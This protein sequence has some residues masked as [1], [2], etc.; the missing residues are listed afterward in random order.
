MHLFCTCTVCTK[1]LSVRACVRARVC[2]RVAPCACDRARA[3]AVRVCVHVRM[4]ASMTACLH[5]CACLRAHVCSF[6]FTC[7]S[8]SLCNILAS[9]R[10]LIAIHTLIHALHTCLLTRLYT[11]LCTSPYQFMHACMDGCVRAHV[12]MAPA[13]RLPYFS[14]G[15]AGADLVG[16]SLP[17]TGRHN[18]DTRR[19]AVRSVVIAQ[20]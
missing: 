4:L 10:M 8:A 19:F 2:A 14:G 16:A 7:P 5:A 3:R 15:E 20:A 6:P 1:Q 12:H 9:T 13:H 11:C 17:S 18:G